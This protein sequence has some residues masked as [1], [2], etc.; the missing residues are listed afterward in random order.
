MADEKDYFE[1]Q[2][3]NE[4]DGATGEGATAPHLDMSLAPDQEHEAEL[5]AAV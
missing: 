2:P 5:A 4:G 3:E 1:A